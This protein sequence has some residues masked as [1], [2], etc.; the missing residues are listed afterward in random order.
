MAQ[1]VDTKFHRG[2][3]VLDDYFFDAGASSV[4][5]GE[6]TSQV[7]IEAFDLAPIEAPYYA[8][9]LSYGMLNSQGGPRKT[10]NGEVLDTKGNVIPRLYA[11][12][13]F[14]A[15]YPYMYNGGGNVSDAIAAGRIAGTH[16]AGLDNWDSTT[17]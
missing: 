4:G 13:E 12:G 17:A 10:V 3:E 6:G 5:Y 16:C 11:A 9:D 8:L 15:P 7:S 14:G 1:G 2:E